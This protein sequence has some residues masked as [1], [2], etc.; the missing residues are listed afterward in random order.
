MAGG[1]DGIIPPMTTPFDDDGAIDE[2]AVR[3]Q[4]RWLIDQGVHGIAV[5]GSTGEG[6]TLEHDEL[7]RLVATVVEAA[8][9]SVP[10]IA[11]IIVDSTP[12]CHPA[13]PGGR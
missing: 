12:R 7:R 10:V 6:Q 9:G 3:A 5:G 8:A 11:G 1:L 2:G 4:V 13:R